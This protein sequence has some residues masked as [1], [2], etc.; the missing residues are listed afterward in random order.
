[1]L[2]NTFKNPMYW[3]YIYLNKIHNQYIIAFIHNSDW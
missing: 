2:E 3:Y 1:M